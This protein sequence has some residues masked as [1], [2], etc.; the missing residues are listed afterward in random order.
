MLVLVVVGG[1]DIAVAV[2]AE[3]VVAKIFAVANWWCV[4]KIDFHRAKIKLSS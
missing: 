3:V 1:G 2:A 4:D